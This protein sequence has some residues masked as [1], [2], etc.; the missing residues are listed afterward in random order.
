MS[1]EAYRA[2]P[3]N[4][5]ASPEMLRYYTRAIQSRVLAGFSTWMSTMVQVCAG[6]STT[7][8]GFCKLPSRACLSKNDS[9]VAVPRFSQIIF[10]CFHATKH[11]SVGIVRIEHQ[12]TSFLKESQFSVNRPEPLFHR[13]HCFL[14]MRGRMFAA[15]LSKA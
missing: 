1:T 6:T 15:R 8:S 2:Q 11:I 4:Y 10:L 13:F 5:L 3:L 12:I 7:P 9:E 14:E